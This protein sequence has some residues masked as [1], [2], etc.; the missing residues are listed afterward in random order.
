MQFQVETGTR[1][2][3]SLDGVG[4]ELVRLR[5]LVADAA[6]RLGCRLV[7]SGTAPF[8]TPGLAVTDQP[9][10]QE[11]AAAPVAAT[12][13]SGALPGSRRAGAGALAALA[14]LAARHHGELTD[15]RRPRHGMGKLAVPAVV[16]LAD[17]GTARGMAR[18][19]R[20]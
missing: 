1:V 4:N 8:R 12:C 14:R 9:R 20:L 18:R 6:T 10:Y 15:R 3:T 5:R 11:L 19:R 13:T 16:T 2:C 7:A 17:G